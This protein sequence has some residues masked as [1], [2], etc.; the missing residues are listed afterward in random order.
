MQTSAALESRLSE[1]LM[2]DLVPCDLGGGVGVVHD[3]EMVEVEMECDLDDSAPYEW[4]ELRHELEPMP[5]EEVTLPER[6]PMV[7]LN[8]NAFV[9]SPMV[10][11]LPFAPF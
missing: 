4:I 8:L 5:L 7:A 3:V 10:D 1:V 2:R 11:T 9:R 6:A